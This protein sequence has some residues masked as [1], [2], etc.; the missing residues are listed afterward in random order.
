MLLGSL[1]GGV[2][3]DYIKTKQRK[4]LFLLLNLVLGCGLQF[5]VFNVE[6]QETTTG[7]LLIFLGVFSFSSFAIIFILVVDYAKEYEE[8]EVER[9][10]CSFIAVVFFGINL[11]KACS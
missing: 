7:I 10:L 4:Q 2:S 6:Y 1:V 3:L 8:E 5:V 9:C 11:G